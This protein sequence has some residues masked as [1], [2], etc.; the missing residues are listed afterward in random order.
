MTTRAFRAGAAATLSPE[1]Q[2]ASRWALVHL[3]AP[4]LAPAGALILV[5]EQAPAAS[6]A[7]QVETVLV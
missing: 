3:R 4:G 6:K 5:R 1:A 2:V 7:H